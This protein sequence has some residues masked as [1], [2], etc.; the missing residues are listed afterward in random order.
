MIITPRLGEA[1]GAQWVL[2]EW[3]SVVGCEVTG[4]SPA[5]FLDGLGKSLGRAGVRVNTWRDVL[6]GGS[7]GGPD[8]RMRGRNDISPDAYIHPVF[9]RALIERLRAPCRLS[10]SAVR[11]PRKKA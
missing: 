2:N 4:A 3:G 10:A 9:P 1:S 11:S 5:P 7:L 8:A 6:F